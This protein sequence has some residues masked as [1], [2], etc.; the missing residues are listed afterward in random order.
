MLKKKIFIFEELNFIFVLLA[1]FQRILGRKVYF[2]Y[3]IKIWQNKKSINFLKTIGIKWLNSQDINYA[4]MNETWSD[5]PNLQKDFG[6]LIDEL[7]INRVLKKKLISMGASPNDLKCVILSKMQ[8]PFRSF[9][10]IDKYINILK[11]N[12]EDSF[13]IVTRY[14]DFFKEVLE[15]KIKNKAVLLNF[16]YFYYT[17]FFLKIILSKISLKKKKNFLNQKKTHNTEKNDFKKF[18]NIFLPHE[19]IFYGSFYKKDH[20]YS[21]KIN[22]NLT[23]EK[24]LHF[25]TSNESLLNEKTIEFYNKNKIINLDLNLLGKVSFKEIVITALSFV[26]KYYFFSNNSFQSI[27][28][29]L[30]LWLLIKKSLN[31]LSSIP[32]AENI[33]F[34][35]DQVSSRELGLAC[36]IKRIKTIAVQERNI[37]T[38]QGLLFLILDHYYVANKDVE[39][40]INDN[41]I[42]TIKNVKSIGPLRS[43]LIN[44]VN[45]NQSVKIEK[46]VMVL[47][48][49]SSKNF[50]DNGIQFHSNWKHNYIFLS[51]ILKL[52]KK[53]P[54][55]NFIIKGKNYDFMEIEYFDDLIKDIKQSTNL[56]LY[57]DL[58]N[59]AYNLLKKTA[60]TISAP[61]SMIDEILF[62]NR[63]II[64]HEIVA[65]Y[66]STLFNYGSNLKNIITK[67]YQELENK[68]NLWKYDPKKFNENIIKDTNMFF[69]ADRF[70]TKVYDLLHKN[71]ENDLNYYDSSNTE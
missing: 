55:I 15:K 1:I 44:E 13:T 64:I 53:N 19:G 32:N 14:P 21:K 35:Y 49:N 4:E 68:F 59:S 65:G 39:K 24:I 54:D 51:D 58:E 12:E 16:H 61:T 22:S 60:L 52:S 67:N 27:F 6:N 62:K 11:K 36:R 9:C 50:Y 41:Q 7:D 46:N 40:Y 5:V 47:D 8:E 42:G 10:Y 69:P 33:F 43:D 48:I 29:F 70:K 20:F 23:P 30:H 28:F 57:K 26:S 45:I 66:P 25:S 38:W 63:S 34:G 56:N 2:L 17:A 3:L 31:Q 18:K 71:L 37:S